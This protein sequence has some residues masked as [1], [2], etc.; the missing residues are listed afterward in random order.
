[1]SYATFIDRCIFNGIIEICVK[2]IY[3]CK[4]KKLKD[5][6]ERKPHETEL[7]REKIRKETETE[8]RQKEERERGRKCGREKKR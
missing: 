3:A 2:A 4:L 1:M 7:K 5:N 6:G 8:V